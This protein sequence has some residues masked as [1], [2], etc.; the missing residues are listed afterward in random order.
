MKKWIVLGMFSVCLS[1][2]TQLTPGGQHVRIV[3]DSNIVRHC[4]YVGHVRSGSQLGGQKKRSRVHVDLRNK[5]A[6]E[7][8]DVVYLTNYGGDESSAWA[9]GEAYNCK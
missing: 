8:G 6:Q 4:H 9:E 3:K 2:C 5:T 7:G 1:A